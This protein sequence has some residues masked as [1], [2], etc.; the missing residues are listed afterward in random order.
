[1][2]D[3]KD[4]ILRKEA[5]EKMYQLDIPV[6]KCSKASGVSKKTVYSWIKK[7]KW[8]EKK[9]EL[10]ELEKQINFHHSKAIIQGLE[11]YASDP[12][13]NDLQSLVSLIKQYKKQ[14]EV[15]KEYKDYVVRFLNKTVDYF[16][17]NGKHD[18]AI[19]FQK[20]LVG[21]AEFLVNDGLLS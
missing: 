3:I 9:K 7:G 2:T 11:N 15:P 5:C 13:N 6:S 21:L 16:L 4:K 1:M 20:C 18:M 19:E 10:Q 14:D 8:N 17:Q 12:A